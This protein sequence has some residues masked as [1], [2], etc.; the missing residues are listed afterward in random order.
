MEKVIVL[1][2]DVIKSRKIRNKELLVQTLDTIFGELTTHF[3]FNIPF[4]IYRG[5]SFQAVI[6]N[7]FALRIA[8]LI[9][10]GLRKELQ[11]SEIWDARIGIGIGEVDYLK[12]TTG[13]SNGKA[14]ELS[15]EA[16]ENIK[17]N[18]GRICLRT[19]DKPINQQFDTLNILADAI[20]NRWSK[21]V[22]EVGYR[23]LLFNE[24]QKEIAQKLNISQSAV[25]QRFAN[26]DFDAI[27]TYIRYFE[28]L[29]FE[30]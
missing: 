2:G 26:A 20:T 3:E 14:F 10:L 11:T 24:T 21:N 27:N 9:R 18:T 29:N 23:S 7:Q 8:L 30:L 12:E 1:T 13:I 5:D 16:L 19:D 28:S 6:K 17:K 4:E 25:Q 22:A 15:G